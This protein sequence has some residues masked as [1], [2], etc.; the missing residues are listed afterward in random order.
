MKIDYNLEGKTFLTDDTT[1]I[2]EDTQFLLTA[3]NRQYFEDLE[4]KPSVITPKE[5]MLKWNIE[6]IKVVGVTGTNGKTT[7]TAAIY[8][9]LLDLDES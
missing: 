1:K 3:Q 2:A 7:V 9:F 4:I 5:L 8:S 6:D